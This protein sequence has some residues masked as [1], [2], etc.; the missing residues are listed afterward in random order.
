MTLPVSLRAGGI[1]ALFVGVGLAAVALVHEQTRERIATAERQVVLDRLAAVLP[2]GHDNAPEDQVYQRPTPLDHDTPLRIYPAYAGDEYLGA[3]VEV[4]TPEG[5]AGT[6][7]LLVGL[8]ADGRVLGV[9]TVA[10]RETPGLGDAIETARSDWMYG[11]DDRT[12]GDPPEDDW[13]VR[14]DGG[15]FDGITGATITARAVVDAVREVLI[16]YTAEPEA[17]RGVDQAEDGTAVD[18]EADGHSDE[19]PTG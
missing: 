14:Q 7:R 9:R 13:R 8:D 17:Y 16:D 12:L 2:E 6:I 18:P 19:G 4:E 3:A 5:Y 11:F 1:L 10:H 15:Q